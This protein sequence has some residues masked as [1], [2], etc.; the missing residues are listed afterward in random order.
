[1]LTKTITALG[2]S[3]CIPLDKTMSE[4]LGV[5]RGDAVRIIFEGQRMIVEPLSKEELNQ[6]VLKAGRRVAKKHKGL[7]K[8]LAK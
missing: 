4:Q 6:M 7:L 1:M 5:G 8:R 3:N 2:N